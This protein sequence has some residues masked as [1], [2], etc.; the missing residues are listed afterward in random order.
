[1]VR[2]RNAN[3]TDEKSLAGSAVSGR[4]RV[5]VAFAAGIVAAA[6]VAPFS[7]WQFTVLIGWAT[8]A[9]VAAGRTWMQISRF[10]PYQT[11]QWATREDDT[12]VGAEAL[13][14]SSA[15]VSLIGVGFGMVKAKQGTPTWELLLT[16]ATI[17]AIFAFVAA[18]PHHLHVAVRVHLLHRTRRR[19]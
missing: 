12:R 11:A 15:V 7:P 9:L 2:P 16:I 18:G 5:V 8:T 17:A 3:G 4:R 14:L 10:N 1:M 19:N 13:L 6:C